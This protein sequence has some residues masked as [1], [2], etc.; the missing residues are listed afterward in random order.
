MH[1]LHRRDN[2]LYGV[3]DAPFLGNAAK[4]PCIS[5]ANKDILIYGIISVRY[6]PDVYDGS[7]ALRSIRAGK[8]AERSLNCPLL[9]RDLSLDNQF[10]IRGHQKRLPPGLRGGQ[11]QRFSHD[12][13]D[14]LVI[15]D[16]KRRHIQGTQIESRVMAYYDSNR[17][18]KVSFLILSDDCP[19][20][21]R[22]EMDAQLLR[23]L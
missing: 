14:Q 15:V 22:R 4:D 12:P 2:T 20:V 16:T 7:P 1:S 21:A 11:S 23:L 18:G 13:A 5:V 9:W 10:R 19:V 17:G 6:R 8:F 3:E